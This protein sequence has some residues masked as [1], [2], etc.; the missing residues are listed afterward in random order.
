MMKGRVNG[1][2]GMYFGF[3]WSY[4][5]NR[6][7]IYSEDSD[8]K[9]YVKQGTNMIVTAK[10]NGWYEVKSINPMRF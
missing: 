8:S 9:V 1:W 2:N 3:G 4:D 10:E 5:N 7:Q 6:I